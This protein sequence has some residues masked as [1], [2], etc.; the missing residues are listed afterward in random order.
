MKK[1]FKM[2]F[3]TI[4]QKLKD[5]KSDLL[6]DD[7]D[8]LCKIHKLLKNSH[9]IKSIHKMNIQPFDDIC[10]FI[11]IQHSIFF[12]VLKWIYLAHNSLWLQLII[13]LIYVWHIYVCFIRFYTMTIFLSHTKHRLWIFFLNDGHLHKLYTGF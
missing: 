10:N 12:V 7:N 13:D 11:W 1:S 8:F 4:F 2:F 3:S 5:M 9:W 6:F